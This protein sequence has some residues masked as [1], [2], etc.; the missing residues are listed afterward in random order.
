MAEISSAELE[1]AWKERCQRGDFSSAILGIGTIRVMGRSGDAAIQFPRI[2][3][4]DA[5]ATLEPDEQHAI[6]VAQRIVAQAGHESLTVFSG[7]PGQTPKRITEFRPDAESLMI[8]AR[9]AGG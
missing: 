2:T 9:I 1:Q 7:A 4:L 6:Q 5:L 8:V 3:S